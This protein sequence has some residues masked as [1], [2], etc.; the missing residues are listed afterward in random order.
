MNTRRS[1]LKTRKSSKKIPSFRQR[2]KIEVTGGDIGG[3][4]ERST[5]TAARRGSAGG[6]RSGGRCISVLCAQNDRRICGL[7][8]HSQEI[9]EHFISFFLV[10]NTA[11]VCIVELSLMSHFQQGQYSISALSGFS[12]LFLVLPTSQGKR[13]LDF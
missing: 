8:L 7:R 9:M 6:D 4:G 13:Q 3:G 12:L 2:S 10:L 5:N 1:E 11:R